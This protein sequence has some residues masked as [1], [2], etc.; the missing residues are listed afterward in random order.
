MLNTVNV[1]VNRAPK[2]VSFLFDNEDEIDIPKIL[3]MGIDKLPPGIVRAG[4]GWRDEGN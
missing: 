4:D 3:P 1:F 2:G